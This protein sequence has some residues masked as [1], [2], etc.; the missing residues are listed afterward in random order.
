M[1]A[2]RVHGVIVRFVHA[3]RSCGS[4]RERAFEPGQVHRADMEIIVGREP[5]VSVESRVKW[6]S[7]DGRVEHIAAVRPSHSPV[8]GASM[9]RQLTSMT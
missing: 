6:T 8:P 5:D 9:C 2:D 3:W 4:V 7:G 1:N